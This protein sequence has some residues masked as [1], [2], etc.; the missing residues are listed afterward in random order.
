MPVYYRCKICGSEHSSSVIFSDET[1]FDNSIFESIAFKCPIKGEIATYSKED[2][3]WQDKV[4]PFDK[5]NN[6]GA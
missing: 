2:M 5:S 3:A 1:L 6:M 4:A